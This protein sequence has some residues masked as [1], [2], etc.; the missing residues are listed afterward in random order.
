[1]D[2]IEKA[3]ELSMAIMQDERCVR[4]QVAKAANEADL[5][6][7]KRI[8]AFNLKKMMLSGEYKKTPLDDEKLK[9]L[10]EEL[11]DIY[12]QIMENEHMAEFNTA[13]KDMDEMLGHINGII[14]LAI[15]G[16]IDDGGC[17]GDCA[18][19]SGCR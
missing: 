10:E 19:C 5:E 7:Q 11:R 3:K 4:M 8:G 17:Q 2:V 16:E 14:Q 13:K 1:M 18:G 6:L 9:K 12:A 15:S